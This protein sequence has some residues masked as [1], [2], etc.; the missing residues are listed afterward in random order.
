MERLIKQIQD[1]V[2]KNL[3]KTGFGTDQKLVVAVSGGPDSM[4]LLDALCSISSRQGLTLH[5]AHLNHGIRPESFE[6]AEQ[7]A[8]YFNQI[9]IEATLGQVDTP[10]FQKQ[11]KLSLEEAARYLRYQFLTGAYQKEQANAIAIAH[12]ADDQ[13]ETVLM[14]LIRGGGINGLA[15]MRLASC[16]KVYPD[17]PLTHFVRP[18]LTVTKVATERYCQ[19]R[20]LN[21]EHDY[22]NDQTE[23]QRNRI[24]HQLLPELASFN[25]QIRRTLCNFRGS[26]EDINFV[27]LQELLSL[28]QGPSGKYTTLPGGNIFKVD[29][30]SGMLEADQN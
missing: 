23:Y 8:D 5:P 13:A 27:H 24:R 16:G 6:I 22:T 11:S 2:R 3:I 19:L 9:G 4:T 21:P 30:R 14:H 25:P 7:L 18:L 29:K 15:G 20:E 12:T 26:L 1:Q 17:L 10:G 28:M